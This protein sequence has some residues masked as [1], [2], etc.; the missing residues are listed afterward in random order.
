MARIVINPEVFNDKRDAMCVAMNEAFRILM[1]SMSF[2]PVSEPTE[3]QRRFFSDTAYADDETMLRRTIIARICTFDDSVKNPTDEQI[4]ESCEF[5]NSVLESGAPQN[6]REQATVQRILNVL[7][8]TS[9]AAKATET[10]EPVPQG[11][12]GT[13][14]QADE[15][16]GKV[17]DDDE[18]KKREAA[19]KKTGAYNDKGTWRDQKGQTIGN[20]EQAGQYLK[21]LDALKG[22][23][24][25]YDNGVFRTQTGKTIGG[26]LESV[27]AYASINKATQGTGAYYDG[28][29][30]WRTQT[31]KRLDTSSMVPGQ[32][33][34]TN[35]TQPTAGMVQTPQPPAQQQPA[36]QPAAPQQGDPVSTAGTPIGRTPTAAEAKWAAD[37]EKTIAAKKERDRQREERD[38]QR[39]ERSAKP[40]DG[41]VQAGQ[42]AQQPQPQQQQPAQPPA[43]VAGI[44]REI[45]THKQSIATLE[46]KRR[47]LL[48]K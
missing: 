27:T 35:Q 3:E 36:E 26:D 24:S 10:P 9:G 14:A 13:E 11:D 15:K 17:Q 33:P 42:P 7:S 2:D 38:R 34:Q 47:V 44:D 46:E 19:L 20:D 39:A 43:D 37:R 28:R 25:Y 16:G 32:K 1:E 23:D 6:Q 21:A 30:V 12:G 8:K 22:T 29:G 48:G 45:A 41:Q 18:R 5:L 40:R 4:Q 31:G